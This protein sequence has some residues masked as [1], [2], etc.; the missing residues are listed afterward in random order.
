MRLL[1]IVIEKASCCGKFCEVS[2]EQA[3][4]ERK[5]TVIVYFIIVPFLLSESVI[6]R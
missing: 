2:V 6:S 1:Q 4:V 3:D 5:E